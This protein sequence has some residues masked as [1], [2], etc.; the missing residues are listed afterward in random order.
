MPKGKKKHKHDKVSVL[1]LDFSFYK[2]SCDECN[3]KT[4]YITEKEIDKLT[5]KIFDI[6]EE[7]GMLSGGS[8]V[9]LRDRDYED[10]WNEEKEQ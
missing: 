10:S 2:C 1:K 4:M 7:M 6:A 8:I 5:R 9:R 3:N